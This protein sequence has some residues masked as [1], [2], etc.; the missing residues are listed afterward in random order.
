MFGKVKRW[1]GIEGVKVELLLPDTFSLSSGTLTGQLRFVSMNDQWVEAIEVSLIEKYIRGRR[2]HRLTDEYLLGKILRSSPFLV[3]A[4]EES[5]VDFSIAFEHLK[6]EMDQIEQ[7]NFVYKG[8][9]TAAKFLKGVRSVY[10]VEAKVKVRG[11]ALQPFAERTI[12]A[13]P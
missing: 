4:N 3:K 7:K 12:A 1:L 2:K 5:F 8:V 10:R 9:V 13:N 6:S 11:T